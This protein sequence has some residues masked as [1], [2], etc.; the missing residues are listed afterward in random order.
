MSSYIP[1]AKHFNS[2]E[3]ATREL[4]TDSDFRFSYKFR[5]TF[6]AIYAKQGA[7]AN[8][9]IK[10][11]YDALKRLTVLCVSL[12][13]KHHYVGKL[14]QEIQEQMELVFIKESPAFLN[15]YGL[16]KALGC[17]HYQIEVKHLQDLRDLTEDEQ[18][19][20]FFLSELKSDLAYHL[21]THCPQYQNAP[22]S[23]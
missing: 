17:I 23:L 4:L 7:A 3:S 9:E 6:P 16:L 19:A 11:V 20:L 10:N 2:C 5:D 12:Q 8:A 21:A 15:K 22:Y 14:D 1:S 18:D 13:Y